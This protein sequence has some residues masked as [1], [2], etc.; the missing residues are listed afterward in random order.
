VPSR[1]R[2]RAVAVAGSALAAVL[3]WSAVGQTAES[4]SAP[5]PVAATA[6]P[7]GGAVPTEQ[8]MTKVVAA[9]KADPNFA[10]ERKVNTLHWTSDTN[11]SERGRSR[12]AAW[13]AW[14]GA[15]FGFIA[16]SARVLMWVAIALAVGLVVLYIVRLLRRMDGMPGRVAKFVAPSHVQD[17]DIRPESLPPDIGA[18]VRALWDRGEHRAAL[19]L[20]YRG[21]L[22]RLVHVYEVPIRDSSTEGDCLTLA[23]RHVDEERSRYASRLVRVWQRAVYGGESVETETVYSLCDGF[24]PTLDR[25]PDSAPDAAH[26]ATA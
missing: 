17:L 1:S 16:Q 15:L 22:S 3:A 18:A 9:I 11:R 2:A 7:S 10:T 6:G 25:A 14:L 13:L 21:L 5:Q 19:A 26:G 24:G 8:Q 12:F 4:S 20:L 23:A